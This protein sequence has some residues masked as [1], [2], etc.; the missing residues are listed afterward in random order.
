M[1][2]FGGY[3]GYYFIQ[4]GMENV[5]KDK[6]KETPYQGVKEAE[7]FAKM[8]EVVGIVP[9]IDTEYQ[10]QSGATYPLY[11][12]EGYGYYYVDE[13]EF[14]VF[15]QLYFGEEVF[16]FKEKEKTTEAIYESEGSK[17]N[18]TMFR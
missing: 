15:I 4:A 6:A 1:G 8:E 9:H 17:K 14:Q 13:G 10:V 3:I 12:R 5:D 16:V 2:F 7:V 18:A 11:K